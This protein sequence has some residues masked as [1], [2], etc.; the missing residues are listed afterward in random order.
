LGSTYN[1]FQPVLAGIPGQTKLDKEA[2][3][4]QAATD[5]S[6]AFDK[7][8][9]AMTRNMSRMGVSP[10]AGRFGGLEQQW[11]LAR[12]AAEAGAKSRARK[13]I[14]EEE[15][16]RSISAGNMG[17]QM[18]SQSVSARNAGAGM[19]DTAGMRQRQ[20]AGAQSQLATESAQAQADA[21]AEFQ[22]QLND[23]L[24]QLA[25]RA[26]IMQGQGREFAARL[27]ASGNSRMP[28][29]VHSPF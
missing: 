12:A 20:L 21:Q 17:L 11:G 6:L 27:A 19:M 3:V 5:T 24:A 2:L 23:R 29:N 28:I 9:G 4:G 15:W 8:Q 18:A 7:S 16:A 26:G 13:M 10:N 25:E 1:A 14:R 22:R